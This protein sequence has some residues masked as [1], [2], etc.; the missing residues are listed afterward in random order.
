MH[1]T[2]HV[3]SMTQLEGNLGTE[4][5]LKILANANFF[6]GECSL[7]SSSQVHAL[8]APFL[9]VFAYVRGNNV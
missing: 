2:W 7:A 3:V 1:Y 8:V 4:S 6:D 9:S 5:Q